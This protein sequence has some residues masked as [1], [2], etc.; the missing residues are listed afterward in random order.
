MPVHNAAATLGPSVRSVLSQTH[1]DLEL[2]VTDDA[3]KD[4]SPELLD[5]LSATAERVRVRAAPERG[6]AA[7]AR[8][9]AIERARGDYIAFLDSDDLWLPEKLERQLDFARHTRAALTY[10][11]YYKIDAAH[12]GEAE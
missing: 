4:S 11:A 9:L 3:S 7:R 10:T 1:E 6:G 12:S 5:E 2:L 8:N